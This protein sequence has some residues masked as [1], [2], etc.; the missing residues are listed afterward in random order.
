MNRYG[1]IGLLAL[2]GM[3]A[4]IFL[5]NRG[6]DPG[7]VPTLAQVAT[8]TMS[9]FCPGLTVEECPSSPSAVLRDR[10]AQKISQRQTNR[11]IDAWLVANYGPVVLGKPAQAVSWLVPALALIVGAVILGFRARRWMVGD[12]PTEA[13]A[14]P[15]PAVA[16]SDL[17]RV[18]QELTAF[19]RGPER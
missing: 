8:R 5:A 9:P 15:A 7:D 18:E 3:S 13:A 6:P 12:P 2:V 10:I 17:R 16:V 19:E 14:A 1:F 11:Q 4:A